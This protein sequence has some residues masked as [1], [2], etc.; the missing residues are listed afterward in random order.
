MNEQPDI[1]ILR[2]ERKEL[3]AKLPTLREA[4]MKAYK[5]QIRY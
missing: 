4:H 1:V 3:Q 2:K 5:D